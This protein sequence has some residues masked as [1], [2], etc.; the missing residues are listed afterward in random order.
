[1]FNKMNIIIF[2][3]GVKE[4]MVLIWELKVVVNFLI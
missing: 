3:I 4:V 2:K 1:M